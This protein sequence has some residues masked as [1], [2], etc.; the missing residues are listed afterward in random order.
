MSLFNKYVIETDN[1]YPHLLIT[2]GVHGDEFE[3]IR[4]IH[5]LI[6]QLPGNLL[7]GKLTLVPCVNTEAFLLGYRTAAD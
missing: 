1:D 5:T 7:K 2:A 4:C 3:S 6:N